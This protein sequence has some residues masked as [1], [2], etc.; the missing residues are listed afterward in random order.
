VNDLTALRRAWEPPP[1]VSLEAERAA[2]AALLAHVA[3]EGTRR[4]GAAPAL[5]GRALRPPRLGMRRASLAGVGLLLALAGVAGVQNLGGADGGGDRAVLGVSSASA[6]ALKQAAAVTERQPFTAPRDDQWIYTE[7]EVVGADGAT[8]TRTT[9]RRADGGGIATLDERGAL[10]V[11][12]VS[13]V[14]PGRKATPFDS[15]RAAAALPADPDGLLRWAY[16]QT[17]SVTGAGTTEDAEVFNVLSGVLGQG[18]LPPRLRAGIFRA[19]ARVPGVRVRPVELQGVTM[20]AVSQ[21]DGWL[22]Q[23]LLLDKDTYAYRGQRSTVVRDATLDPLKAGTPS[24]EVKRG[25]TATLTR[26]ATAVVDEPGERP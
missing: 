17:A 11:H 9:W 21:T 14:R 26:V 22:K 15:Y 7:D 10:K 1:V 5:A 18:V 4:R 8:G 24:G 25:E 3:A 20:V 16:A 13:E 19:M 2:R 6:A 23:E 12:E